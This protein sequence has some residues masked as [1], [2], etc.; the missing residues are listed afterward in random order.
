L[1]GE[2][3]A[4]IAEINGNG[5][6][7]RGYVYLGGQL[8]AVQQ[9]N[10][11]YWVHQDPLAKSKRVTNSSGNVVSTVELDPWGGNTNRNNNDAFQ[12]HK[13]NNY[14]RDGNASDEA[15][16]RRYN[17]W[18]SK[19]DQPDPYDGSYDLSDPQ[20]FNRYAYVQNDPVNFIDP[21]GLQPCLPGERGAQCGWESVSAGFWGWGD[22]NNR[23]RPRD[24]ALEDKPPELQCPPGK[25]CFLQPLEDYKSYRLVVFTP[26]DLMPTILDRIR[27]DA[28]Y[29]D[30]VRGIKQRFSNA[31][32][33]C[34][35]SD[36]NFERLQN[37]K[38]WIYVSA[39]IPI[40][41]AIGYGGLA[42]NTHKGLKAGKSIGSIAVSSTTVY[43]AARSSAIS[44]LLENPSYRARPL[45]EQQDKIRQRCRDEVRFKSS[46]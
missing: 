42:F 21:S 12:P 33:D 22:L 31:V 26:S 15:M 20:S 13:F 28:Q 23:R 24:W 34:I 43:I 30:L 11:V 9:Q 16:F 29:N 18:W 25:V 3:V 41:G 2:V 46:P 38:N 10:A 44:V 27:R 45:E 36:P 7:Q 39:S 8:V 1:G 17:R 4:E 19:F 32:G 35:K 5:T 14:E 6:W 37:Q 40:P